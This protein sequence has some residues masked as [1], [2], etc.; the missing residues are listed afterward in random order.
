[1]ITV[2]ELPEYIRK[3][4]RLLNEEERDNV[5]EHIARNPRTGALVTGTGGV[6]KMRW[7]RKGMGKSGGVRII[8]F[9]Y[10]ENIPVFL[11]TA[12]GK[13][14]KTNLTKAECNELAKLTTLLVKSYKRGD[15]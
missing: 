6:R 10:N 4:E 2:V 15:K 14:E 9:F 8:Y 5:L 1:M 12:F 11:L 13:N 7:A 3:S